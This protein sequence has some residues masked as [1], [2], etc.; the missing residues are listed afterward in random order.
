MKQLLILVLSV[1]SLSVVAQK[2]DIEGKVLNEN[3]EPLPFAT[4]VLLNKSDSIMVQFFITKNDGKFEL[5]GVKQG[6]YILQISFVGYKTLYKN[7]SVNS[8]MVIEPLNLEVDNVSLKGIDVE[9]ERTPM[10]IK[11]DT[12]E[13]NAASFKTQPNANVED[14]LKKLP[15]VE[16]DKSGNVNAQGEKVT[17]V[18]VDG[19]EFFGDDPKKA[20]KNLP[21]N[22][23]DKVQ[24]FDKQ[25]ETS[26]FTGVDDGERI[27]TINL[28]LKEGKKSGYFGNTMA[29][30]G[31]PNDLYE[32]KTNINRFTKKTQLSVLGM[33][34]NINDQ[35]FSLDDY[36]DFMGGFRNLMSSGMV[37]FG[38]N[39]PTTNLNTSLDY[40]LTKSYAGGLNFNYDF[41]KKKEFNA[42]YFI[43]SIENEQ[44]SETVRNYFNTSDNFNTNSNSYQLNKNLNHRAYINFKT[45][46]DSLSDFRIKGNG[47]L[48]TGSSYLTNNQKSIDNENITKSTFSTINDGTGVGYDISTNIQYRKKF[49]KLGRSVVTDF[50]LGTAKDDYTTDYN[51]ANE[52]FFTDSVL[53]NFSVVDSINQLQYYKNNKYNYGGEFS[54]TEPLGKKR[55]IELNLEHQASFTEL[56]KRFFDYNLEN[57]QG[58]YNSSL[59][60]NYDYRQ[61]SSI[62]GLR[63]KISREKYN[64]TIGSSIQQSVL[65]GNLT[66]R[67]TTVRKELYN[68]I[69]FVRYDYRFASSKRMSIRYKGD[70]NM[71]SITQLQPVVDNTNPLQ[72]YVGN[73]ELN[74]EYQHNIRWRYFSFSQFSFTSFFATLIGTYT[75]NK[76]T[77]TVTIDSLF[78]QVTTPKNV[79]YDYNLSAFMHFSTPIKKLGIKISLQPGANYN[80][81]LIYINNELTKT[82][83]YTNSMTLRVDNKNKDKVDVQVG[84]VISH[85]LTKYIES[86]QLDQEFISSNYYIDFTYYFLKTFT[87]STSADY[88][89]YSGDAFQNTQA[90]PIIKGS[91]SKLILKN[92]GEIKFRVFDALNKNIGFS[93][94][95]TLNYVEEVTTNNIS[96]YYM[97]TFTYSLSALG[98]KDDGMRRFWGGRKK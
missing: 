95:S 34:N 43:N 30:Y 78:R 88:T 82:Q 69:P 52:Y 76:I 47:K 37:S 73:P 28:V 60:N 42:N 44:N 14:L 39:G 23:I 65:N 63:F 84:T 71:P 57:K 4:T 31:T 59:S 48:N 75:K 32:A 5:K 18:L 66:L 19:K 91:I 98:E 93:R 2:F 6:D 83:R 11:N 46:I 36:A 96:R 3:N 70:V 64:V 94:N 12:V 77:N 90:I 9:A 86:K 17:K 92:K 41:G 29:G 21:A 33:S 87:F 27:K 26:E 58:N 16:V 35:G 53:G 61:T 89:V 79:D 62:A 68:Y 7:I 10:K 85:N 1:L 22:A 40:G 13:Y 15:G 8:N 55:Y 97:L 74:A 56:D 67:D 49:K 50:D 24:V 81:G 38:A 72:I 20:T 80:N 45:N 51:A 25:S 54:Y